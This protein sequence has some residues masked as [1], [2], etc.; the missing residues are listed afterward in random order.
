MV[1]DDRDGQQV[2]NQIAASSGALR[3]LAAVILGD[4]L[5]GCVATAV[6]TRDKNQSRK[7]PVMFVGDGINDAP[8]L[9][10]AQVGVAMGAAGSD[11][12]LE[13]ADIA[14][15]HDNI[16]KLPWLIRFS[17]RMLTIITER[18]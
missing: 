4:H 3:S 9:A 1:A 8:A 16:A 5:K 13:T 6:Q 10:V 15:I 7:L 17:R 2:L 12:A 11:V 14:L 18:R